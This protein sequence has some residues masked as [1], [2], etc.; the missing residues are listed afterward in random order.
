MFNNNMPVSISSISAICSEFVTVQLCKALT[1]I[2][3]IQLSFVIFS[4]SDLKHIVT[5]SIFLHLF[6]NPYTSSLHL[7]FFSNFVFTINFSFFTGFSA[8]ILPVTL[9]VFGMAMT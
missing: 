9:S 6:F 3:E 1:I 7:Q 5:S 2:F 4:I 8:N